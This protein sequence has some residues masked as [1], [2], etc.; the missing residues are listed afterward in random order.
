MTAPPRV[1]SVLATAAAGAVRSAQSRKST[2]AS[3][4]RL[5]RLQVTAVALL[6]VFGALVVTALAVSFNSARSARDTLAQYNRL[7]DAQVQALAVQQSA[8]TWPLSPSSAVRTSVGDQL[9]EL[10]TTLADAAAV[11]ADRGR[12]VPLTGA[13]VSYGMTLQDALNVDGTASAVLLAKSDAQLRST[14]LAPLQQGEQ[15]IGDRVVT[16]LN[17]SWVLWVYLG[18]VVVAGG[19]VAVLVLL[20]RS[21]HRYVNHGVAAGLVCAMV[22]VVIATAALGSAASTAAGFDSSTRASLDGLAT[23]RTQLNQARADE[24]LAIGLRGAGTTYQTRWTTQYDAAKKALADVPGST[25]AQAALAAYNTAHGQVSAKLASSDWNG[26]AALA[27]GNGAAGKA[28]GTA[29]NA[30]SNLATTVRAPLTAGVASAADTIATA[31]AAVIV[32]TLA[33]AALATWGVARRI[34][35][36][37]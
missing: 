11:A 29:D 20:A 7:A 22:S 34:E 21:S 4:R 28:F 10:A 1:G 8:N 17:T 37:R 35:E 31:I 24:L 26:A 12:I 13:L 19:L 36:Y 18:A 2:P 25:S 15:A 30:V 33:G 3:V 9:G 23:T 16:D 27:V 32:L 14:I 6:L 5:R